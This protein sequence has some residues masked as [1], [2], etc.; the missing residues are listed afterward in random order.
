MTDQTESKEIRS[1]FS[2]SLLKNEIVWLILL[3]VTLYF[4]V[5]FITFNRNDPGWSHA[6]YIT[7]ISN[8]GGR[9]GAWISDFLLFIFGLSA[10][11][12][13]LPLV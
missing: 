8:L 3:A 5:I 6:S 10:W 13:G 7:R 2:L 9:T 11:W 4:F 12:I 1:N